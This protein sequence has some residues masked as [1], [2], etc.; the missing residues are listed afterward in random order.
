MKTELENERELVIILNDEACKTET[1]SDL[2]ALLYYS[3]YD[4]KSIFFINTLTLQFGKTSKEITVDS[5]LREIREITYDNSLREGYFHDKREL[6]EKA[7]IKYQELD[8]K[9]MDAFKGLETVTKLILLLDRMPNLTNV[10]LAGALFEIDIANLTVL[11]RKYFKARNRNVNIIVSVPLV[12]AIDATYYTTLA[13]LFCNTEGLQ[14][15]MQK[16][17]IRLDR[18]LY[19]WDWVIK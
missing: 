17:G 11:L 18:T 1:I 12:E 10:T 14:Y 7:Q 15:A 16:D 3:V 6:L 4:D 13:R 8:I 9:E 19:K 2:R 5:T